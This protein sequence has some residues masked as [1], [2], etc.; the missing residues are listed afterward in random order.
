MKTLIE[1]VF[2]GNDEMYALAEKAVA[3]A[4]AK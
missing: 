1:R 2:N 4:V 3:D